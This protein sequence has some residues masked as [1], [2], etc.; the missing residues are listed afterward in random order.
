[1]LL[2][3]AGGFAFGRSEEWAL[4]APKLHGIVSVISLF[5]SSE[6]FSRPFG[7]KSHRRLVL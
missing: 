6:A 3:E 7:T 5:S 4:I 2:R 1:M